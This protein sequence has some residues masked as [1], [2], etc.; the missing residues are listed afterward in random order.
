MT[1]ETWP[2]LPLDAWQDTATTLHLWT[3]IVGKVRLAQTPWINHSWHVTLYVTPRGLTTSSIPYGTN[4]FAIDF[5]FVDHRLLVQ[6]SDGRT[7]G[8]PLKAM[9]VAAF[10]RSVMEELDRL[11]LRV[12]FRPRPCEIPNPIPFDLDETHGSYDPEYAN[13]YWRI[14]V[15]AERV[16]RIFRA[17]F[18]GKVSPIHY[19]WGGPDLAVTRFSGRTAPEHPGGIPGLNDR[20][21]REAYSHEVS[22][23]GFWYGGGP[24]PRP[25]FYSYAYPEPPGFAQAKVSPA[26]AFYT[27]EL[28]EFLLPYETVR[29]AASPDETLLAFLQS[30]Y[31]A[32]ADLGR[33][34][35][36][37]LERRSE[38]PPSR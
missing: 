32:A 20:V 36:S 14:L 18:I 9:T 15:Q 4:E 7:G 38:L 29:T 12:A 35:R 21:T 2:A 28:R 31:E 22:S 27:G 5:D 3:Q 34:D 26:E 8:F 30:T 1:I 10:Y 24:V 6:S 13:R 17:P 19:F 23:A 25:V 33:W 11:D 37:A 16:F